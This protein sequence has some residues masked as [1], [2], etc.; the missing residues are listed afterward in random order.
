MLCQYLDQKFCYSVPSSYQL[1]PYWNVRCRCGMCGGHL[2]GLLLVYSKDAEQTVYGSSGRRIGI[3]VAA[4]FAGRLVE[5]EMCENS[6]NPAST[7]TSCGKSGNVGVRCTIIS[8]S[9][10]STHQDFVMIDG[11]A[12]LYGGILG[13]RNYYVNIYHECTLQTDPS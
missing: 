12:A 5:E 10:C 3:R 11:V 9:Y 2:R 7:L 1:L 6:I 8:G 4:V 13:A